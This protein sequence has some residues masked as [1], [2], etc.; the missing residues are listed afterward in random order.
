MNPA[1]KRIRV[2]ATGGTIAEARPS[3]GDREHAS[4][5]DLLASV[6]TV[7]GVELST[8][9]L[10]DIPST[11]ITFAH[12]MGIA[13]AAR[14][15]I[16][17]GAEGVVVTHGTDTLEE[18]AYL[19]DLVAGCHR[20][21]VF[22]GAMLPPVL[23]GADGALNLRDAILVAASEAA[24]EQGVL[25]AFSGE[26]HP[27]QDVAK[28][29]SMSLA[30]FRSGEFGPI[31]VV[32]EGRVRFFRRIPSTTPLAVTRIVARVEGVKCYAAM[33]DLQIRALCAARVDGIVIET[34]GS[35]Q[36][37][38]SLMGSI[39]EAVDAGIAVAA[40]TRCPQGRLLRTHYGLSQR[41]DGD[42]ADLIESGVL[43]SDLQGPKARI[44]LAVGL[45]AGLS[46][47]ELRKWF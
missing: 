43:F 30:A 29:H 9:D 34:L 14:R 46:A 39:R 44:R 36:V 19:V 5:A 28:T 7:A 35:G 13:S 18:S 37:P 40:T 3:S 15:A 12:M 38:P 22:T 27:A 21:I 11:F 20:P 26:I 8:V 6:G 23:P 42:E 41:V 24:T 17:E 2:I 47:S 25:V 16:D 31:G 33:E 45:S 10:F 4:G 1:P 32:E